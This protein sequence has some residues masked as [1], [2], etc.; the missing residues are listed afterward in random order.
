MNIIILFIKFWLLGS[1]VQFV[2]RAFMIVAHVKNRYGPNTQN[3]AG[4][5]TRK[6]ILITIKDKLI[7]SLPSALQTSWFGVVKTLTHM[8]S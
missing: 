5:V 8:F 4:D 2:L 6:Q 3:K 7:L 1:A